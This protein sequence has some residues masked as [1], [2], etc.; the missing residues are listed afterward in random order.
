MRKIR[1]KYGPL[2][3]RVENVFA[4]LF[5]PSTLPGQTRGV[6][7]ERSALVWSDSKREF[8]RGGAERSAKFGEAALWQ[9]PISALLF[10]SALWRAEFCCIKK[11]TRSL[12]N[13]CWGAILA[14]CDNAEVVRRLP[15]L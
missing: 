3:H 15:N 1:V 12:I 13:V 2:R 9:L 11:G 14:L 10:L 5:G 7:R 4:L 6:L 8:R